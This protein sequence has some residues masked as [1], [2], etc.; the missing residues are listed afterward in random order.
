[1]CFDRVVVISGGHPASSTPEAFTKKKS[2]T[3]DT[4]YLGPFSASEIDT[5]QRALK[6]HLESI[7]D[8]FDHG[9]DPTNPEEAVPIAAERFQVVQ[10]LDKIE[11]IRLSK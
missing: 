6:A 11:Y 2:S 5:I 4:M 1:M 9:Q 10:I 8:F 3:M 7:D